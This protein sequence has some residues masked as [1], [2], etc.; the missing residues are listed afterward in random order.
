MEVKNKCVVC[1]KEYKTDKRIIK[2]GILKGGI[3]M[4]IYCS[5][6]CR[7]KMK[8]AILGADE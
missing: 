7:R 1:K 4:D 3:V 2:T 8:D 6:K 5:R